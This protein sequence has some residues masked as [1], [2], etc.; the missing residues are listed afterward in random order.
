MPAQ[1]ESTQG[2]MVTLVFQP[3]GSAAEAL[4]RVMRCDGGGATVAKADLSCDQRQPRK[5]LQFI[6]TGTH[7]TYPVIPEFRQ[8]QG[9]VRSTHARTHAH[10][11]SVSSGLSSCSRCHGNVILNT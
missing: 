4:R 10:I 1:A 11:K 6:P 9:R 5:Q 2:T 7:Q 3:F 8:K